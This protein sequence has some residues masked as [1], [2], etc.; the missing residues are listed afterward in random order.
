ML[1]YFQTLLRDDA[2][3]F[4]Q[5]LKITTDTTMTDIIAAFNKEYAKED[6]KEVSKYKFDQMR[7]DTTTE[8]ITDFLTKLKKTAKQAYGTEQTI[9]LNHS[10]LQSSR[11]SSRMN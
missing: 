5:I 9:L 7:Y 1:I 4:W 3:E 2:I 10:C 6:L 11:S 8:S